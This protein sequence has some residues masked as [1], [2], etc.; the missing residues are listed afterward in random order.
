MLST[1][2][3]TLPEDSAERKNYPIVSGVLDYFPAAIAYVA[4]ISK[5]GN[6]KHNK[7]QPLHW[8]RDKSSDHEDCIGRHLLDRYGRD[9]NGLLH[10]GMLAWRALAFLELLLEEVEGA[11]IPRGAHVNPPLVPKECRPSSKTTT[12]DHHPI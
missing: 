8:A 4:K 12:V 1:N 7:G 11:P 10:A 3:V 9:E 2:P 5:Y 6:D